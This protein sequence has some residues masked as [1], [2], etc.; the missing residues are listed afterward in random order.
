[1]RPYQASRSIARSAL[2]FARQVTYALAAAAMAARVSSRPISGTVPRI[3][4]VAGS[5]TSIVAPESAPLPLTADQALLAEELHVTQVL[6]L[7]RL[8]DQERRESVATRMGSQ[9]GVMTP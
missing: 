7:L 3:D 4:C 2:V 5:I 9:L 6:H 1:M 8:V